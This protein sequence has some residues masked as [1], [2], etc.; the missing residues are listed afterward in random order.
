MNK[1]L[2]QEEKHILSVGFVGIAGQ[3]RKDGTL[4]FQDVTSSR[5]LHPAMTQFT[6][7]STPMFSFSP[8][9]PGSWREILSLREVE[10]PKNGAE[11]LQ[12]RPHKPGSQ[13]PALAHVGTS[14]LCLLNETH[15]RT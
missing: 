11:Y 13:C 4:S 5:S 6:Y 2:E 15:V 8:V 9:T 14:S 3:Q 12:L 7:P 1:L 10:V